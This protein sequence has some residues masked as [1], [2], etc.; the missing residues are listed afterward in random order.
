[1]HVERWNC[2]T[3]SPDVQFLQ[4]ITKIK[5]AVINFFI[6]FRFVV[7]LPTFQSIT[8]TVCD[9]NKCIRDYLYFFIA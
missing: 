3:V 6:F 2:M 5:S 9:N 4:N 8:T 7:Q 1:M